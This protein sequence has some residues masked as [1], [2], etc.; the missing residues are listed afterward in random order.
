MKS[1]NKISI[2]YSSNKFRNVLLIFGVCVSIVLISSFRN[3]NQTNPELVAQFAQLSIEAGLD[4]FSDEE[5]QDALSDPKSVKYHNFL[6]SY[7]LQ[8][9]S[10]ERTSKRSGE[11]RELLSSLKGFHNII[12]SK[13]LSYF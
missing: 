2:L 8:E 6:A 11:D 7:F 13:T 5:N 4:S 1:S 9:S 10:V 3:S 12:I